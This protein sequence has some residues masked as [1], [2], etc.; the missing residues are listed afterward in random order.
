MEKQVASTKSS[1]SSNGRTGAVEPTQDIDLTKP[2]LYIN[3]ELSH[4]EF[5]RRVL[6]ECY[7]RHPLLE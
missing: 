5:N 7:A 2:S 1:G 3:R 4:I 6:Q